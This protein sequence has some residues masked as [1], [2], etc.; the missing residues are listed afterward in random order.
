VAA[1]YGAGPAQSQAAAPSCDVHIY[2]A[3][4]VHSVGEDFDAVHK[5]DQ[6]LAD[7]YRNAGRNLN[8]LSPDR[9]LALLGEMQLGKQVGVTAASTTLHPEPL[10][11]HQAL[12]PGPRNASGA[13]VVE[14]MVPQIML[15]RGGLSGRS[16][17]VFGVVRRYY[18]GALV[19]TYS[20]FAAGSM[21]GFQLKTPA[22][23]DSATALVEQAYRGAVA[24]LV[25]NSLGKPKNQH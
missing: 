6:D 3:E 10:T 11:R 13:C 14:V 16:L 25:R 23:A 18:N 1:A 22:D 9:Q 2:P 15:E 12:Q 19:A 4:G 20:G 8:W 5:V 24:T 17:R 21:A 7:Y